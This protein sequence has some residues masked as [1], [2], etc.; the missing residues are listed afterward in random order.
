LYGIPT[1]GGSNFV[2]QALWKQPLTVC[3]EGSQKRL[4]CYV[5]DL[6]QGCVRLM[7]RS[8]NFPGPVNL[9]NPGEFAILQ[10]AEKVLDLTGSRSKIEFR[11]LP[12]DD[13]KQRKPD[14]ALAKDL[15]DWEPKISLDEGLGRTVEYLRS[16]IRDGGV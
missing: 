11:H 7:D 1:T 4:F 14:T 5:D 3:G 9:G 10:L 12:T 2:V 13:P 8:G 16:L 15:L 6:I